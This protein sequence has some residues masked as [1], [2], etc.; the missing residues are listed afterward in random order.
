MLRNFVDYISVHI[1]FDLERYLLII[2]WCS[3]IP[4]DT[5]E[6][7]GGAIGSKLRRRQC[8]VLELCWPCNN[9]REWAIKQ[10]IKSM[11]FRSAIETGTTEMV[12]T[13]TEIEILVYCHRYII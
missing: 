6:G 1:R 5:G 7:G 10:L 8:Q 11:K 12:N 4:I 13:S 3:A 9:I 2:L